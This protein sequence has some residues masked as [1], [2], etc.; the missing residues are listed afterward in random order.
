MCHNFRATYATIGM[1]PDL[2]GAGNRFNASDLLENILEP[3]KVI[4]DQ[5]ATVDVRMNDGDAYSGR[6][7]LQDDDKIQLRTSPVAKSPQT[8]LKKN[9]K[10]VRTSKIS[11]M[12]TG[13]LDVLNEDEILDLI[14]Y[15]RSGGDPTDKAFQK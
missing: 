14:A 2:T 11:Q 4:S 8:I 9:V 10:S 1:G 12:P 3:S 13:L 15:L 7:E 6:I 5:Y